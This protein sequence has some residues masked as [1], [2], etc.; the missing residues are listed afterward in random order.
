MNQESFLRST[1]ISNSMHCNS[2]QEQAKESSTEIK[3]LTRTLL[4]HGHQARQWQ[5][6]WALAYRIN[7]CEATMIYLIKDQLNELLRAV[8]TGKEVAYL[9]ELI[10]QKW[11]GGRKRKILALCGT[12]KHEKGQSYPFL[13]MALLEWP[14]ESAPCLHK[15]SHWGL[16]QAKNANCCQLLSAIGKCSILHFQNWT[17]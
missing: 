4:W 17:T 6:L 2:C 15:P 7:D 11:E 10:N 1:F 16:E 5:R 8:E 9:L 14:T 13:L 3:I 12:T